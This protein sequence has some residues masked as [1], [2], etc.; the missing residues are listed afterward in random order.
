[1]IDEK[2]LGWRCYGMLGE[3]YLILG[4]GFC[5]WFGFGFG[6]GGGEWGDGVLEFFF[7]FLMNGMVCGF[8]FFF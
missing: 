6:R 5:F 7:V 4:F 2:E 3:G 1:M 8:F